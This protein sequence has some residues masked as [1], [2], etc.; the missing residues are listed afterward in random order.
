MLFGLRDLIFGVLLP[1]ALC[2]LAVVAWALATRA[3]PRLP[4]A[5]A[6][7]GAAA[8][9]TLALCHAALLGWPPVPPAS[10]DPWVPWY[11]VLATLGALVEGALA[12]A[13]EAQGTIRPAPVWL[14]LLARLPALAVLGWVLTRIPTSDAGVGARVAAT[15]GV[16]AAGLLLGLSLD[17]LVAR[18]GPLGGALLLL[19]WAA[20]LTGALAGSG[21]MKYGQLGGCLAAVAGGLVAGL[22]LAR[23]TRRAPPP[24]AALGAVPVVA[25]VAMALLLRGVTGFSL[26]TPS[27][28]ALLLAPSAA[29]L[30]EPLRRSDSPRRRLVGEA[31]GLLLVAAVAGG[32]AA[33][34]A[35]QLEP[36][37]LY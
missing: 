37:P 28:V 27:A 25:A 35:A 4:G 3:R 17:L 31:L 12:R 6:L 10:L 26:V 2:A 19:A 14:R 36:T 7:A 34:S 22:G 13:D 9:P 21:S 20:P 16:V 29:W 15:A 11:A 23:L 5:G 24:A 30:A 18:R 32:A 33:W 1:G 8:G